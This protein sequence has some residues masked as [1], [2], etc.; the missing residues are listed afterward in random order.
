MGAGAGAT[1]FILANAG[2]REEPVALARFSER[3][4]G[5][6][7][8]NHLADCTFACFEID[9]SRIELDKYD[10]HAKG[11]DLQY[12]VR[13]TF[14]DLHIYRTAATGLGCDHLQDSVI[15]DVMAVNCGRLNNGR[16]PGGAGIGIG[17]GGWGSIERLSLN[18]CIAVGNAVN[19]IFVELQQGK[20][21][22]P[23]GIKITGGHC[24]DNRFGI[25]DWGADGLVVAAC[26]MCEN[27]E[28]GFDVSAQG[29]SR[30]GGRG[31]L[32]TD[33]M[34]DG[35]GRDG[36]S[37]GDTF[38]RYT[39]RGNR[40]S[41]NGRYG[42]QQHDIKE[43][44][45]RAREIAI[46]DNDIWHNGCDGIRI[47]SAM[48]DAS[49]E[50][51]RIRNNGR[52]TEG[53]VSRQG[54]G[55][56]YGEATLRDTNAHWP[57][58]GHKGKTVLAAG[59]SAIVACNTEQELSLLPHRP[60]AVLAWEKGVPPQGTLYVMQDAP[61]VR[62]GIGIAAPMEGAWIRDNRIWENE[63]RSTQTHTVWLADGIAC[64]RSRIE[65]R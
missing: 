60:A 21:P 36:I 52:R 33:C 57:A 59:M 43:E 20:W 2:K 10:P 12:M 38:G 40:I 1:R 23:R 32:V 34:I 28:C 6:S 14:R 47:G 37:I 29:V 55:V 45:E 62:A 46:L 53:A 25:S 35:N 42:Y 48:L 44:A 51:N 11:L 64:E 41:H 54:A 56:T 63:T 13:A 50:R 3:E 31:G 58:D 9:G 39:V 7:R 26:V 24:V 65:D 5:A 17:I 15:E 4:H 22:P 30:I 61:S 8:E 19:G 27:H 18:D 49:I 16:Q